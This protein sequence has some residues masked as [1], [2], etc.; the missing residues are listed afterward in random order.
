MCVFLSWELLVAFCRNCPNQIMV[1]VFKF[2][3]DKKHRYGSHQPVDGVMC[4]D[5]GA[6]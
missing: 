3:K 2:E 5:L 4:I 6:E 1:C